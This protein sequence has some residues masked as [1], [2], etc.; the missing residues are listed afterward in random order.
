MRLARAF[1]WLYPAVLVVVGVGFLVASLSQ[2]GA[3][4]EYKRAPQCRQAVTPSCYE[5]FT[6]T[7]TSVH[8][9]QGR[10]GE[11]DDVVIETAAAGTLS[12]TLLSL[13][14]I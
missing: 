5:V 9:N 7:I 4:D 11:R 12:V 6:G 3:V 2:A 1:L 10:S 13:I 14:H 8:V